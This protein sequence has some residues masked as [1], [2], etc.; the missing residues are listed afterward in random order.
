MTVSAW[1]GQKSMLDVV[2]TLLCPLPGG[3]F[4]LFIPPRLYHHHFTSAQQARSTLVLLLS[5][6]LEHV[7]AVQPV[8]YTSNGLSG[9]LA[10]GDIRRWY[11]LPLDTTLTQA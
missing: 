1:R 5:I 7:G 2:L 4:T 10:Q 11:D 6:P 3:R 8:H 9:K